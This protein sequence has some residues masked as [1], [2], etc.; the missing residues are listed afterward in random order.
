MKEIQLTQNKITIVDDDIYDWVSLYKWYARKS[1]HTFYAQRKFEIDGKWRN[2]MLHRFIM[3]P[4]NGMSVDHINRNG[5]DN[6]RKNLR[7][8]THSENHFN[9]KLRVDNTSGHK[10]VIN[11][12][13]GKWDAYI[14]GRYLGRF[15]TIEEAIECRKKEFHKLNLTNFY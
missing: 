10:G 13:K 3:N 14:A 9:E 8:V 5:L 12:K 15:N 1:L 11:P 4:E 7:I 6:R 2:I